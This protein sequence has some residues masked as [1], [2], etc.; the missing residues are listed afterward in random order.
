MK[1]YLDLLSK[2]VKAEILQYLEEQDV[3][4]LS[5]AYPKLQSDELLWLSVLNIT[6]VPVDSDDSNEISYYNIYLRSIMKIWKLKVSYFSKIPEESDNTITKTYLN[7]NFNKVLDL[8]LIKIL[9]YISDD[10]LD[11]DICDK[12]E[13]KKISDLPLYLYLL[14]KDM[15]KYKVFD[16]YFD[17]QYDGEDYD[18]HYD[19]EDQD[20]KR[21][22]DKKLNKLLI[23]FILEQFKKNYDIHIET[24]NCLIQ[25]K[26]RRISIY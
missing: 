15:T 14:K 2:D 9:S 3:L 22:K 21:K 12:R 16:W 5:K 24:I 4:R 7:V 6:K 26:I 18:N 20:M 19:E 17:N 11:I 13:Y 25:L 8:S 23:V 1:S 10:L